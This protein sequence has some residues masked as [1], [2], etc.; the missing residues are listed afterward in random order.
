MELEGAIG[1]EDAEAVPREGV[2][3]VFGNVQFDQSRLQGAKGS[4]WFPWAGNKTPKA[5]GDRGDD[6]VHVLELVHGRQASPS[7]QSTPRKGVLDLAS[8]HRFGLPRHQLNGLAG[9]VELQRGRVLDVRKPSAESQLES[10]N[11]EDVA[12][13]QA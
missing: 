7:G 5:L 10:C 12:L 11:S 9:H 1:D 6:V 4:V 13:R 2:H 3:E 8:R